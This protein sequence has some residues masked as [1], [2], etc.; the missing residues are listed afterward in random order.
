MNIV[1][2]LFDPGARRE[3]DNLSLDASPGSSRSKKGGAGSCRR[4]PRSAIARTWGLAMN[5]TDNLPTAGA[6]RNGVDVALEATPS[7][8]EQHYRDQILAAREAGDWSQY[9]NL[10]Q[11]AGYDLFH[12]RLR[13]Q[14]R[15]GAARH[16]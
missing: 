1:N 5:L 7:E 9:A 8:V 14:R 2:H 4:R 13:E 6:P 15:V 10:C 11:L 16:G 3:Y 12:A